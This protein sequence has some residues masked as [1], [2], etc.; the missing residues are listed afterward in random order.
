MAVNARNLS[1]M[2]NIYRNFIKAREYMKKWE[3]Y[4]SGDKEGPPPQRDLSMEAL[5]PALK[6]EVP[7]RVHIYY[8]P[9]M[10][11]FV[12]MKKEFGFD[13]QFIHS[14]ESYKI[15]DL[16]AKHNVGCIS[17]PLGTRYHM[18]PDQMR[19]IAVL[20][21]A[22]VKVTLHTDHPVIHQKWQ[23]LNASMAIR[24]GLSEEAALKSVT[25]NPA[26]MAGVDDRIGSIEVGKDADLVVLDGPWF[27]LKSRVKMVFVDGV[28]VG[29]RSEAV[30]DSQEDSQ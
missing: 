5:V 4:E 9:D 30:A 23:R 17:L 16:L 25:I 12:E 20:H 6:H 24:Y 10:L 22:G 21:D 18:N 28:L 29:D 13:L 2:T 8:I 1:H 19:G 11:T 27:E 26:E 15:A 14:V 3:K 7:V